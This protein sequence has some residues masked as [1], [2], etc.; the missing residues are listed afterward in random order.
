MIKTTLAFA[1]GCILILVLPTLPA[2]D[3]FW[4][5]ILNILLFILKPT[6]YLAIILIAALWTAWYSQ[7]RLVQQLEPG[8]I[9]Q[10][11]TLT[12]IIDSIPKKQHRT[13]C[14]NITT[15]DNQN[16]TLPKKISLAW[17]RPYPDNLRAG[18]RWQLDVKLKPPHGMVNP[19]GFDYESWLFSTGYWRNRLH[20]TV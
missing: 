20:K 14:F 1:T 5:V 15:A 9:Q 16:I 18:Q 13:L 7:T 12:G 8:L 3:W 19:G 4:M 2:I 10:T 17:Y 6:R 11:I